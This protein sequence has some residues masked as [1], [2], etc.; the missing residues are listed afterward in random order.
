MAAV[1][2]GLVMTSFSSEPVRSMMRAMRSEP[3]SRI[4]SSSSD[5]K[6]T[7]WPGSPWR[8]E[9]PRNCRSMLRADDDGAARRI[10][11]A[12]E[13]LDFLGWE[14]GPLDLLAERGLVRRDPAHLTLLHPR[15]ELDVGPAA[16]HVGRDR[17]GARLA[18]LRHDLG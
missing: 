18:R 15:P 8:P 1:T 16:G 13:P 4:R 17:D 11:V 10:V 7:L 6:N 2:H 5:R 3:N 12:G 9:R 14:V